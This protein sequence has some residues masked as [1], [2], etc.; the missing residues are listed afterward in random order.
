[1]DGFCSWA[2]LLGFP[3]RQTPA[4]LN[5]WPPSESIGSRRVWSKTL[6]STILLTRALNNQWKTFPLQAEMF[7]NKVMFASFTSPNCFTISC[8]FSKL[9]LISDRPRA[10]IGLNAVGGTT[11]PVPIWPTLTTLQSLQSKSMVQ[12]HRYTISLHVTLADTSHDKSYKRKKSLFNGKYS[13][14]YL[15]TLPLA[16]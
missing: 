12:Q 10:S 2:S 11:S 14:L 4:L 9:V 7:D 15:F 16:W 13:L 8:T 6:K 5:C 1:M 3:T